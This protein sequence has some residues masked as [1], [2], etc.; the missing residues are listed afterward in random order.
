MASSSKICILGATFNTQNMGVGALTAST[1]R[2]ILQKFPNAEVYLLDYAKESAVYDF[3]IDGK[4]VPV[5]LI[6]M[7]FS[8]KFYLRNNIAFLILLALILK[9]LPFNNLKRKLIERSIYLRKISDISI[10]SSIAGGDS[11]SDIYGLRRFFYVS[12]P[13]LLV[14]FLGKELILLPQ[15]I[16]PFKS[17]IAKVVARYILNHSRVIYSRDYIGLKEAEVFLGGEAGETKLKFCYDVAFVLNPE[18]PREHNLAD[19]MKEKKRGLLITGLNVSGLL[20]MGGYTRKNMFGLKIDYREFIFE[21]IAFLILK[22]G[23]TVILVPHVFGSEGHPESDS[24]ACENIYA[25]L[26]SKYKDKLFIVRGDYNQN[27]IKYVIGLC[28]FFVGSRMHACIAAL[29][30]NIPAVTVAY[31]KKFLGVLQ[32]IGVENLVADPRKLGKEELMKVIDEAYNH[33][34]NIKKH[35]EQ[36][37]PQVKNTV[38]R[39]FED[40]E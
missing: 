6:N 34:D 18:K 22:K 30:Q 15:T 35:L 5:T 11:F 13:Q 20:L 38:L 32:T 7:R 25:E 14:L 10:V 16:G 36:T 31:S 8:K 29:S 23:T 9:I 19:I 21:L 17:T 27:E 2:C 4:T 40:I 12:L 26:K 3:Y 1:I 28:D 33:K 37:M 39:L 24:V